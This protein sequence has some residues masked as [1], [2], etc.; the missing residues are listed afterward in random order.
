VSKLYFAGMESWIEVSGAAQL[1]PQL[2]VLLPDW[3]HA[4]SA[5]DHV[6]GGQ[7]RAIEEAGLWRFEADGYDT[8]GLTF[9]P[10]LTASLGLLGAL[11]GA[12]V[13]QS[14]DYACL[15]AG[16]IDSRDGII[17]LLG[18]NNTGKSTLS[19]AWTAL[20]RR[21]VCDDRL[22][23]RFGEPPQGIGMALTPKLRLPLP[24]NAAAAFRDFVAAR[25]VQRTPTLSL[26]RPRPD[27]MLGFGERRPLQALVLLE[28]DGFSEPR[29]E[30]AER[31]D[32]LDALLEGG[33]APRLDAV[34]RLRA[35]HRLIDLPCL[36]LIYGDSFAAAALLAEAF[37]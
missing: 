1:L 33:F 3:P 27:E 25:E 5:G 34:G 36:R 4:T 22:L 12:A 30:P 31:S 18:D 23:I 20:G 28:R 19:L 10:G 8:Q 35:F 37:A 11:L 21:F 26:L 7:V 29:L 32:V 14:A 16:A 13:A 6:V 17:A 2:E 9:D 15:H 24:P